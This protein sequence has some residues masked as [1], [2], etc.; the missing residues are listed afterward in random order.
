[1]ADTVQQGIGLSGSLPPGGSVSSGT[2]AS[3]Q[4]SNNSAYSLSGPNAQLTGMYQD[5]YNTALGLNNT[6]Y[7]NILNAYQG[8]GPKLLNF[9]SADQ[10]A[11]GTL[12][13]EVQGTIAN[14]GAAQQQ[15]INDI[16]A[17]QSGAASEQLANAG[18]G[19]STVG[20]SVQRGIGL[21]AAKAGVALAGQ[22]AQLQ[23][24]Y[25]AQLGS[26]GIA[27]AQQA[28][29]EYAQL[30]NAYLN[31]LGGYKT[32]Y[33]TWA[34]NQSK[35]TATGTSAGS[36]SSQQTGLGGGNRG[37]GFT[38]SGRGN[39]GNGYG[40][41][42]GYGGYNPA[43]GQIARATG[44]TYPGA[45]AGA[46]ANYTGMSSLLGPGSDRPNVPGTTQVNPGGGV[47]PGGPEQGFGFGG[48]AGSPLGGA[49]SGPTGLF[50][51]GSGSSLGP[52]TSFDGGGGTPGAPMGSGSLTQNGLWARGGLPASL[53]S[54]PNYANIA[55]AYQQYL[56]RAPD[57][58]GLQTWYQAMASGMPIGNV[59]ASIA[60][61]GGAG[62]DE[63]QV[64]AAYWNNLGRGP[65]SG[66]LQY[67]MD[68]LNTGAV[69]L[70]GLGPA[71]QAAEAA[72]NPAAG[73]AGMLDPNANWGTPDPNNPD[74]WGGDPGA[75]P[76]PDPSDPS[77]WGGDPGAGPTNTFV[78]PN[79]DTSYSGVGGSWGD[80]G[81]TW[82]T[83]GTSLTV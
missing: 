62:T 37:G 79:A 73:G 35:Y 7:Q 66:G 10:G 20:Q 22:M 71:L 50:A 18:L 67:W 83:G 17:Q 74:T 47:N 64:I 3:Q 40:Y 31:V 24:G 13:S 21:D 52:A 29:G 1:M 82:D 81:G 8:L 56:G 72:S 53:T 45:G 63:Q 38:T 11:F 60:A 77:T 4:Q 69:S 58:G 33:P 59:I 75:G 5:E 49:G 55:G 39:N 28:Q 12:S 54:N 44:G 30:G 27:A 15:N 78:D 25:Q 51:P 6:N 23:G 9:G 2:S 26:A 32:P 57:A 19:N 14:V 61:V 16:Y 48:G 43:V 34:P 42:G 41:G 68:A 70:D 65:D 46:G 36:S 76:T 80:T